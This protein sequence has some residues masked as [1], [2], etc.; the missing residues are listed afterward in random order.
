LHVLLEE[1][2]D[3]AD[4]Q[5]NLAAI[6]LNRSDWP[7]AERFARAATALK[8]KL[9]EAWSNLG[10]ALD[11]QERYADADAAFR[12]AL[13][14]QPAYW[15]ARN[16]LATT[17]RKAG[18][19][20][21]AAVLFEEVLRQVPAESD[22]H[23]ELGDLYFGPLAEP[24]RARAHYNAVLRANPRHPRAEELRQRLAALPAQGAVP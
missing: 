21:E 22:V 14:V 7:A 4:A 19:A 18:R 16:N 12:H 20:H 3:N 15:Q 10:I 23:L 9:A 17:L 13:E 11:G 1:H 2:P 6:A 5:N 24:M 8:P